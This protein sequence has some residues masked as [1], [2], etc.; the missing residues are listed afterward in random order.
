[1][2]RSKGTLDISPIND[3][4][5]WNRE[6]STMISMGYGTDLSMK[7]VSIDIVYKTEKI[8]CQS[9]VAFIMTNMKKSFEKAN[10]WY[11]WKA[12]TNR[13]EEKFGKEVKIKDGEG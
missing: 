5:G 9:M 12:S 6:E 10:N 11:R 1:M 2:R 3:F 8:A 4:S 7:K 13:R